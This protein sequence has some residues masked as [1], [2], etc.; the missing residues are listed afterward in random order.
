MAWP[1]PTSALW[2]L[3][4]LEQ[5][6]DSASA[7]PLGRELP[8]SPAVR[9]GEPS[10]GL[11]RLPA[12]NPADPTGPEK[13]EQADWL[14]NGLAQNRPV[15]NGFRAWSRRI[16]VSWL[17]LEVLPG[18]A[19]LQQRKQARW[20]LELEWFRSDPQGGP[21]LKLRSLD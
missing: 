13:Q 18:P 8:L 1:N 17:P 12:E 9:P 6:I 20:R 19:R 4:L 11:S 16:A 3:A 21:R 2:P 10:T 14:I 15:G 7:S 5:F